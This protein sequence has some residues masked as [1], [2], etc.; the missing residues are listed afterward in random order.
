MKTKPYERDQAQQLCHGT[1]PQMISIYQEQ[2]FH[3]L[4]NTNN[5]NHIN[6]IIKKGKVDLLKNGW[7]V[8]QSKIYGV[9]Y[10][11]NTI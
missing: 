3:S 6:G 9:D 11:L 8:I 10:F 7:K 2:P 1:Y 5:V 4:I